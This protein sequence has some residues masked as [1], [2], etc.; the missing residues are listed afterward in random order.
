M[1]IQCIL[2]TD[3]GTFKGEIIEVKEEQ[4]QNIINLSKNYYESGFEMVLEDGGFS[5]F[6]PEVIKKS[7]LKIEKI[8]V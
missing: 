4:Y 1:K 5:I 2:I 3:F 8:D 6:T 7:I